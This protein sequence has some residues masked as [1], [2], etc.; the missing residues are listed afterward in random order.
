MEKKKILDCVFG[1][2]ARAKLL[3][4]ARKLYLAVSSTFGSLGS[5]VL[6]VRSLDNTVTNDGFTVAS[7]IGSRDKIEQAAIRALRNVSAGSDVLGG[8]GTTNSVILAYSMLRNGYLEI[9]AGT[10][11]IVLKR[12]LLEA[13]K[14]AQAILEGIKFDASKQNLKDIAYI[15][16]NNDELL[17]GIVMDAFSEVNFEGNVVLQPVRDSTEV[18]FSVEPGAVYPAI[19]ASPNFIPKGE[20]AVSFDNTDILLTDIVLDDL[21][22][23]KYEDGTSVIEDYWQSKAPLVLVVNSINPMVVQSLVVSNNTYQSKIY[24]VNSAYFAHKKR[25]FYEDVAAL[26]GATYLSSEGGYELDK[27]KKSDFGV[28]VEG[29]VNT[30]EMSIVGVHD[31][32]SLD[33]HLADLAYLIEKDT[34]KSV[35]LDSKERLEKLTKQICTVYVGGKSE[36]EMREKYLRLEDSVNAVRHALESGCVLGAGRALGYVASEM[37]RD[38]SGAK[39]LAAALEAPQQKILDNAGSDVDYESF[40]YDLGVDMRTGRV[41][42]LKE[43]GI[44]DPYAVVKSSLQNAVSNIALLL[45]IDHIVVEDNDLM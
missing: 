19:L 24:I 34:D 32:E 18:T 6:I 10:H 5:N 23:L 15:S 35:V 8:D 44:I 41:V 26:T 38:S 9:Y 16:V 39:V 22:G 1:E 28:I 4:G 14:E 20:V 42:D 29:K 25:G 45:S 21:A 13:E 12:Q 31:Q 11:Q 3:A 17:G 33:L 37:N 2:E 36:V 27:I 30:A 40:N 7:H 43:N